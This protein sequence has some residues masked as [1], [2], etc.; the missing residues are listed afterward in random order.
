MKRHFVLD[1]S[2][3]RSIP[4][5]FSRLPTGAR[6]LIPQ[7]IFGE[8]ANSD[9]ARGQAAKLARLWQRNKKAIAIGFDLG[10]RIDEEAGREVTIA[11][12]EIV[13]WRS[14]GPIRDIFCK[15]DAD[16]IGESLTHLTNTETNARN[17][18]KRGNFL[19]MCATFSES[20]QSMYPDWA[21]TMSNEVFVKK[22]IQLPN[23]VAGCCG[24]WWRA[25]STPQWQARLTCFPD[26]FAVARY[27]R[28]ILW[29]ATKSSIG[30]TKDIG[31]DWEDAQYAVLSSYAGHLVTHDRRLREMVANIFPTVQ[32]WDGP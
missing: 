20:A 2:W 3:L 15:Y 10:R 8:I 17:E 6:Y 27:T 19:V 4:A 16:S 5:T 25:Y 28:A 29:S 24:Q 7:A 14:T 21:R 9:S 13:D 12:T 1:L 18:T 26:Q 22:W 32:C 30:R 23:L 11:P 31:N